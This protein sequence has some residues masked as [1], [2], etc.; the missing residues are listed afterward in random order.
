[1]WEM[2]D[3]VF[4]IVEDMISEGGA[5]QDVM[6]WVPRP[7]D[8]ASGRG[9]ARYIKEVLK[10]I[11]MRVI[12]DRAMDALTGSK[13]SNHFCRRILARNYGSALHMAGTSI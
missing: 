11:A 8:F 1:M 9:G 13:S 6:Q 3:Q 12:E 4:A 2:N 7:T 10:R 5:C